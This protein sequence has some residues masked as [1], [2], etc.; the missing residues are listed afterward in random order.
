MA[1]YA[2][3]P[4]RRALIAFVLASLVMAPAMVGKAAASIPGASGSSARPTAQATNSG[5]GTRGQPDKGPC[6]SVRRRLW[7][8]SEGWVIKRVTL[9][10]YSAD[11][12]GRA[13]HAA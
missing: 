6:R 1:H 3:A 9:A 4:Y 7:V 12:I 10:C 13:A 5:S 8:D 11:L 2:L